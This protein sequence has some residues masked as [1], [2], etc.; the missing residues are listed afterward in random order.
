MKNI[1]FDENCKIGEDAKL[2]NLII[3]QKK[4]Y[5]LVKEAKYHYRVREDG[6]SAMQTAKANKN[7]FNHSL[8]TF[9]KNLIDITKNHEQKIPLFLQ[10][11]IMHDLKW[12]LLVKDISETP[13]D[14]NEY[15]EFLT[16][17]REV[18]SYI[19]DDV[20]IKTKSISHF[21]L[22]HALKL[23]HGENYSRYVYKSET[24]YDYY[25]YREDKI[26]SKLSDQTLTIEILE[27]NEKFIHIEGFGALCLIPTVLI[28]MLKLAKQK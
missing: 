13:L 12:K 4:K 3:S 15:R 25:L 16:L 27:E 8:I 1:R 10:Y 22:Y 18:L 11:M 17:I 23:K 19:D 26:V 2:V 21:Y 7:W 20:I 5:G 6:S 14:E 24:E 28:F 9:S